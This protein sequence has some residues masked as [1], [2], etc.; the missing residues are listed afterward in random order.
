MKRF[1]KILLF[2][3]PEIEHQAA[4]DRAL[5][6]RKTNKADLTLVGVTRKISNS[7]VSPLT[8]VI[9]ELQKVQV[10]ERGKYLKKY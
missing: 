10:R 8:M 1:K 6:L 3:D 5:S 4:L 9:E 7:L 2:A